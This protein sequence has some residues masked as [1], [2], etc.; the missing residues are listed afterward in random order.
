VQVLTSAT[1]RKAIP[2]PSIE[3]AF[4]DWR[5]LLLKV[6]DDTVD[7]FSR[8]EVAIINDDATDRRAIERKLWIALHVATIESQGC[9]MSSLIPDWISNEDLAG[10]EAMGDRL[11]LGA[12]AL[13]S[14]I[15]ALRAKS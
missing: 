14:A 8:A 11:D 12:Q 9:P 6:D 3:V 1:A 5:R 10:F 2:T 4:A 13:V 15:A 7:D